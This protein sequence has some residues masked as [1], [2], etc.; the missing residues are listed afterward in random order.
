MAVPILGSGSS[1]NADGGVA[2]EIKDEGPQ[3]RVF[4][5][6]NCK[7]FDELPDYVGPAEYDDLLALLVERHQSAGIPHSC[8]P[9]RIGVK[10][11]SMESIRQQIMKQIRSGTNGGLD[12][13]DPE[14]YATRSMFY[15]DAMQCYAK[16]NRPK[17]SCGDWK[18]EN[19]R[20][21]PKTAE[22][23]KTVGLSTPGQSSGTKVYLCDFCP[24]K[25]V[26][27]TKVRDKAG[28]YDE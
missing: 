27:M 23:R 10:L 7:T 26:V 22:L 13:L 9:F 3:L 25:S 12:E 16:H 15:E 11:W 5:C 18:A 24:M 17:D 1:I 28:M 8:T 6:W 19:K 14:Y 4:Y 2:R 21:L 20:L